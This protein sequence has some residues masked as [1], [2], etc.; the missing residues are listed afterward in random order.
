M[1]SVGLRLRWITATVGIVG[2]APVDGIHAP[3][4]PSGTAPVETQATVAESAGTT[5]PSDRP[6]HGANLLLADGS[7]ELG[8]PDW[9]RPAG[10]TDDL[11][12]AL[13]QDG[14]HAA[15]GR[16]SARWLVEP[17]CPTSYLCIPLL[18]AERTAAGEYCVSVSVRASSIRTL[19]A[20]IA[21]RAQAEPS[22]WEVTPHWQRFELRF[23]LPAGASS[24][25]SE[26]RLDAR[27][28]LQPQIIWIDAVKVEA[29]NLATPYQPP[30]AP[31]I[32]TSVGPRASLLFERQPVRIT[33]G[34]YC[35]AVSS[36]RVDLHW[37]LDNGSGQFKDGRAPLLDVVTQAIPVHDAPLP[38]GWYRLELT[39][40]DRDGT[41][42]AKRAITLGV[43]RR[44]SEGGPE[45]FR[46][47][48]PSRGPRSDAL[49]RQMGLTV[50]N[51]NSTSTHLTSTSGPSGATQAATVLSRPL[52]TSQP[53]MRSATARIDELTR[54]HAAGVRAVRWPTAWDELVD[55]QD[56]WL[57]PAVA[58]NVWLDLLT[59]CGHLRRISLDQDT[60]R[61]DVFSGRDR[62]VAF[63]MPQSKRGTR[64]RLEVPLPTA[65]V[66]A[67]D[68]QGV[69]LPMTGR[70][71]WSVVGLGSEPF[72]LLA[73]PDVTRG[74]FA[75]RL[76][77]S[78]VV[79]DPA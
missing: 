1:S 60:V 10:K 37:R 67:L 32:G 51:P 16:F 57:S 69:R 24:V 30:D 46:L 2:L 50:G 39:V 14:A 17:E 21:G 62:S 6:R 61:I 5:P 34:V 48:V 9:C 45:R 63:V 7:F 8:Q 20:S 13:S 49:A 19:I 12:A 58:I 75:L 41:P 52:P 29:G 59:D 71:G 36:R 27:G 40:G 74:R 28:A 22:D 54:Q 33:A 35:P 23:A 56:R 78:R 18:L 66:A 38:R 3:Q 68:L 47:I 76:Q 72:Y 79:R 73:G 65:R 43:A 4:T 70:D 64:S 31:L 53:M 77:D 11:T 26:L 44:L 42:L 55:S 25:P 15:E